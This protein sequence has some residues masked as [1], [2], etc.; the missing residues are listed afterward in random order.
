MNIFTIIYGILA[1][2]ILA[3][4]HELGH[5]FAAK[6]SGIGVEE[7]SIGFGPTIYQKEAGG[8]VYKIGALPIL[9]YAKIKGMEGNFDAP[10]GYFKKGLWSRFFTIF[11]GPL[12]NFIIAILMFTFV[13]SFFG[14]PFLQTTTLSS[15]MKDSPAIS[16]GFKI[17][18]KVI[19]IDGEKITKWDD[20]T[21]AI[22]SSEGKTLNVIVER[23]EFNKLS[24]MLSN[25]STSDN[26]T[27]I[28][29]S[30]NPYMTVNGLKQEIDPGRGTKP[31]I[32][33]NIT[34][35]PIRAI[36]E[37]LGGSIDWN[38]T[39]KMVAVTLKDTTLRLWINKPQAQVDA[40]LLI[41]K[42][43]DESNHKIIPEIINGRTMVPVRFIAE[44]LG[45]NIGWN[46]QVSLNVTPEKDKISGNWMIGAYSA[47]VKESF[48]M[49]FWEG[50][51]WTGN[52]LYR[53][54]ILIPML[55][56]KQGLGSLVGPIGIVAMTSQAASGGF[57]NFVWFMA[58]IS[59]ALGFTNL[60]PL[61]ALDGS[62]IV[63]VIWEAITRK[64]VPPKKQASFQGIGFVVILGLMVLVSLRD[65]MRL[66]GK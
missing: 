53:M 28:L 24:N 30:D 8:T 64:P 11:S 66:I 32:K 26:F 1:I 44:N 49:S 22:R 20:I 51:K 60:L 29:N 7:L 46:E 58:F 43:I 40:P 31:V 9:G 35:A 25:P 10:D 52:L 16:A 45:C 17:G 61:P 47:N 55:F 54:F 12:M 59:I 15:F 18:D 56:T 5:F 6:L 21:E 13:F 48:F 42:W 41:L 19:E 2:M 23:D 50:I 4:F 39:E 38:D 63:L 65:I 27:I 36:V 57:A 37:A 14:N 34:L 33:N 62:W 3:M